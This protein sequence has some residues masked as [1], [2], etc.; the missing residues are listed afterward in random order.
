MQTHNFKSAGSVYAFELDIT[1]GASDTGVFEAL[2]NNTGKDLFIVA[3][4][5]Q[6]VTQSTGA[7]TL[8]IGYT[9]TSATTSS[10]TLIDGLSGATAG[11]FGSSGTNGK[12]VSR[13]LSGK[14]LTVAEASGDV[15]GLVAK[16]HIIA[17]EL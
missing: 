13:W 8:D 15:D 12:P 11:Y 1:G 6:I 9:A 10:D 2:Q 7:S 17:K 16:L 14:W 4:G 5:L 3:I